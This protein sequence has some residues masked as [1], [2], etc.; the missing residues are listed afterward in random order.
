[1][2]ANIKEQISSIISEYVIDDSNCCN[3]HYWNVS[4]TP[5]SCNVC[6]YK[7]KFKPSKESLSE[8]NKVIKSIDKLYKAKSK[9]KL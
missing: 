8:L 1:M 3:C 7:D 4:H 2:D 5:R 6:H 9:L